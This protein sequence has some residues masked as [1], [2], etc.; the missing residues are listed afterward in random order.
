MKIDFVDWCGVVLD[1]L[2]EAAKSSPDFRLG[3]FNE[4]EVEEVVFNEAIRNTEDYWGSPRRMG[5]YDALEALKK[6][7]LIESGYKI[8]AAGYDYV[9]DK[10][11]VWENICRL[12]VRQELRPLLE[13]VNHLSPHHDDHAAWLEEVNQQPLL[14]EFKLDTDGIVNVLMPD[15]DELSRMELIGSDPRPGPHLLVKSTFRGLVWQSKRGLIGESKRIDRL[16]AEWETTSV[17]F[18]RELSLDTKDQKAEFVKDVLGL[19]NTQASGPRLLIIGFDDRTRAWYCTPNPKLSQNRI[20]QILAD[21]TDPV[22]EVRY[23][24]IDYRAGAVGQ[25]EIKRDPRKLPY[26]VAKSVGDRKRIEA[27]KIFVR[28]GSQTEEPTESELQAILAEGER[29]RECAE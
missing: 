21:Y 5:L 17:D 15:A 19:V 26:R 25:L 1:R 12:N 24:Q 29:A 8:A 27:G 9:N 18:K 23:E 11:A 10:T 2:I 6:E 4:Y 3:G 7:G 28:H 14:S 13:L 20:E 22:V 16:V